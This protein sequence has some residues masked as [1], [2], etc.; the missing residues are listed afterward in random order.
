MHKKKD[1]FNIEQSCHLG[2]PPTWSKNDALSVDTLVNQLKENGECVLFYKPRGILYEEIHILKY[3]DFLL[4][5]MTPAQKQM[6]TNCGP[7]IAPL[8]Q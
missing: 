4:I 5:T 6:L 2:H 3:E 7:D 8:F 1:L